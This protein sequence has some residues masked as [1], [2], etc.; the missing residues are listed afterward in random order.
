MNDCVPTSCPA[1]G[2]RARSLASRYCARITPPAPP[3]CA[4]R[5]TDWRP[6][7]GYGTWSS[8]ASPLP[9]SA[10]R[11]CANWRKPASGSRPWPCANPCRT[12]TA[13]GKKAWWWRCTACRKCR[14]RL[15]PATYDENPEWEKLHRA[16]HLTWAGHCGSR[17]L[18][19]FCEQ[20]YDQAY[21][22][23]QLAVKRAYKLRDELAEQRAIVDAI[24]GSDADAACAAL[25]AHYTRTTRIILESTPRGRRVR[26]RVDSRRH[27]G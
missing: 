12:R 5:S 27:P 13:P 10:K 7:L 8:A 2:A 17:W 3:R 11:R 6:K 23:R 21:R 16:F 24:V 4:R 15:S 14:V 26:N 19:A 1:T 9:R 20:L 22:Y 25:E 18:A